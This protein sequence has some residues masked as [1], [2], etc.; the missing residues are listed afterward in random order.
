MPPAKFDA[1]YYRRYYEDAD[2]R[3]VTPVE[4]QHQA[5][6]VAAYLRYL[7]VDVRHILDVGCGI[8]TL[9]R[10]LADAFPAAKTTGV[11]HSEY[12]CDRYGWHNGSVVTYALAEPADLVVCNDVLGYLDKRTCA[13]A[14]SNLAALTRT[15]LYVSVLTE[16]DLEICDTDHTDMSQ[17][18]RPARWYRQ[19][20]D[21][22]FVSVGGGLFVKKP[23]EHPVWA[24]ERC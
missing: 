13:R 20:L 24:L 9:L 5:A 15:A 8:G 14:I 22:H 3:A 7:G 2:T 4:Q 17:R 18:I 10:A 21:A 16:E 1:D 23:L 11:E 6:F 19:K 12:L